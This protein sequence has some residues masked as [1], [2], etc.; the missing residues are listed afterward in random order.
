MPA[1]EA[2]QLGAITLA[3][4]AVTASVAFALAWL[5]HWAKNHGNPSA[6]KGRTAVS[7]VVIMLLAAVSYAYMRRQWLQYVRQQSVAEV[8]NFAAKAQGLDLT[9]AAAMT[10]VQEVELVSRGYR[11]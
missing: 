5:I 10:L 3:G 7:L 4:A 2:P 9:V 1:P 8:S 6:G 11:M